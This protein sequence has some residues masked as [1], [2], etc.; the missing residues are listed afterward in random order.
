[1]MI[2]TVAVSSFGLSTHAAPAFVNGASA[3]K[4]AVL[5]QR[6]AMLP[7]GVVENLQ[8]SGWT[9]QMSNP[10]QI[11]TIIG[12]GGYYAGITV[13]NQKTVYLSNN[14]DD[15]EWCILHELGHAVDIDVLHR[16]GWQPSLSP[17]FA[18]I[19]AAEA[20]NAR[21]P[22]SQAYM[23]S[24]QLEYFGESFKCYFENPAAL[25]NCPQTKNYIGGIVAGYAN[26]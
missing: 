15:A 10:T 4:A 22:E 25:A 21:F 11:G 14:V 23:T 18:A 5:N 1:M 6:I 24:N 7:P 26:F 12:V 8:E 2:I 16:A 20:K 13:E 19:F 17:Q 9:I 3:Q